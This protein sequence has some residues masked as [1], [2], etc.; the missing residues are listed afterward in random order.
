MSATSE[1]QDRSGQNDAS[2]SEETTR[3]LALTTSRPSSRDGSSV[4]L[5]SRR[6]APRE[7]QRSGS[8]KTHATYAAILGEFR[9]ALA[10]EGL[11][12]DAA[13]PRR[14]RADL[15]SL[16]QERRQAFS[17]SQ[18]PPSGHPAS[19]DSATIEDL[20]AA[21]VA[22][23]ALIAQTYA[24]R[25]SYTRY[26]PRPVAPN[27]ANLRLAALS[28]FYTY[29]TRQD[30]LRGPNP[31][32]RV[33]RRRVE[34][35]A[36]ARPLAY[37]DLHT[38]LAAINVATDSGLRDYA[39]LLIALNT[40]RRVAELVGMRREHIVI[41]TRT[42]EITWPRCKGGKVM[43]DELPRGGA[44]GE[45]ADA[46]VA[47]IARLYGERGRNGT[48]PSG[49]QVAMVLAPS[50]PPG[51][52]PELPVWVSMAR[53]GTAGHPLTIRAVS[54]MCEKRLGTSKVHTLRHT[55]A[56]AME[57][58]GAK[59]ARFRRPWAT[60][61]W[62]RPVAT[63]P[64]STRERTGTLRAS[65][66]STA[67]V[68]STS[69]S[70]GG[71]GTQAKQARSQVQAPHGHENLWTVLHRRNACTHETQERRIAVLQLLAR[72]RGRLD[73]AARQ[74]AQGTVHVS[75]TWS[76]GRSRCLVSGAGF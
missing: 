52:P 51:R 27:M 59:S 26:G 71:T 43:R 35:Y 61:T 21:R 53:N 17:L 2:E 9:S 8:T 40:G 42:V 28:S 55:F 18:E 58:A 31:I 49:G 15:A 63:S 29:A 54:Q 37:D 36:A 64:A 65:A 38:R 62:A 22:A 57:D 69:T 5:S 1:P 32:A 12:L 24:A 11:D 75:G 72:I 68:A 3:G 25:P 4:D 45:A 56:R 73:Y 50:S 7:F 41:R 34:A 14:C 16:D 6:L 46:L 70:N 67:W 48:G 47:W 19:A 23:I 76:G 33:E 60:P 44:R 13:D 66:A 39:L 20:T 30:L 10:M 74:G